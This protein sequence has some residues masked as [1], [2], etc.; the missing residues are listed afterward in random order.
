M[1]CHTISIV[2][3]ELGKLNADLAKAALEAMGLNPQVNTATGELYHWA[4]SY[5]PTTGK[6]V[7]R[8]QDRS[9]EL[10]RY[11]SA[12]VVKSQAKRY[13]WT[14]RQSAQ[15]PWQYEVTRR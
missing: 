7:W 5:N 11:Y 1:P 3:V 15:N 8:G 4:G 14:I 10:K 9:T 12:E 6:A 2:T 13:G